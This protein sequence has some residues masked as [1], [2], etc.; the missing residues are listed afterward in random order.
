MQ[1]GQARRS[2]AIYALT[3]RNEPDQTH[4]SDHRRRAVDVRAHRALRVATA[5]LLAERT[6]RKGVELLVSIPPEAPRFV[7]GDPGRIRQVLAN[8]LSNAVKFTARG[9]VVLQVD[10]AAEARDTVTYRFRVR[11]TGIGIPLDAQSRLFSAFMQADGSTTRRYG[12]TGLG[13]AISKQLVTLMGG[14]IGFEST[15]GKGSTFWFTLTLGRGEEI[16]PAA[17][18]AAASL[19]GLR[20][21][22]VDDNATNREILERQTAAWRM[23]S[24]SAVN[25]LDALDQFRRAAEAGDPYR[26][27]LLDVQMPDMDGIAVARALIGEPALG[28]TKIVVLTSLAHHPEE[29]RHRD[30]G[31][32]A[33]LTKPVKQSRLFDTI[34]NVMGYAV[35]R[36]VGHSVTS[37]EVK[38]QPALSSAI[39]TR[40]CCGVGA[41]DAVANGTEVLAAIERVEYDVILMDCQMPELDGYETTRRIRQIESANPGEPRHYIVALTA[42]ALDGDREKCLQAG[43][44][45]YLSKPIRTDALA[46]ALQRRSV[47]ASPGPTPS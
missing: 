39:N 24:G 7:R 43:M 36:P 5:D 46:L 31:I 45:D 20:V 27:V 34:A 3:A 26:L 6:Q 38:G 18:R 29:T 12:G 22:I 47:A 2:R 13:L 10:L 30:L 40:R 41:A 32:S 11:D 9:E 19:D 4:P 33:Y 1:V 17:V 42:H 14:E 23:R 8:L 25:G 35:A 28:D 37:A 44:D 15:P 21:L 16:Q